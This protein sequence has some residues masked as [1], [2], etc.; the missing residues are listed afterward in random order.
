MK[1][2]LVLFDYVKLKDEQIP[3]NHEQMVLLIVYNM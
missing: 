1:V 3:V 2:L